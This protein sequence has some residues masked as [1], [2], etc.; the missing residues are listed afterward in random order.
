MFSLKINP[1]VNAVCL[2]VSGCDLECCCCACRGQ[3]NYISDVMHFSILISGKF[4]IILLMAF[5]ERGKQMDK[6]LK[7]MELVLRLC[8]GVILSAI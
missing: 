2:R 4:L 1:A 7:A 8:V 5:Q 3:F 6:W